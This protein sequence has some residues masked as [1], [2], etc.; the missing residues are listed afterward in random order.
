MAIKCGLKEM[1]R[2]M[3]NEVWTDG[4]ETKFEQ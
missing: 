1:R 2:N 4:T 3:N